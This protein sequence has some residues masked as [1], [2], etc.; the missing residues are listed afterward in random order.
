MSD[1][2]ILVVEDE[3]LIA[4]DIASIL[5]RNDFAVSAI[6]YTKEDALSELQTNQPD[7]VLLDINLNGGIEGIEI[8]EIV[9]Q[10]YNIP[11]LFVTS[12]SDKHTLDKAKH[13]EPSG[14]VTKPFSDEVST[15]Q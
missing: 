10:Q 6:V 8:A 5:E 1:I 9:N 15:Q 13:T 11:F 14:Y 3:P 12:Y 2:N 7:M 4:E